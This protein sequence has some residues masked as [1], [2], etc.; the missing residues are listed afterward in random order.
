VDLGPS[1]RGGQNQVWLLLRGLRARGVEGELLGRAGAPLLGRAREEKFAVHAVA[2]SGARWRAAWKLRRLLRERHYDIV[3]AHDA[4]S[5]T[6]AWLAGAH[7]KARLVATR[8]VIY[9]PGGGPSG[10]RYRSAHRLVAISQAVRMAMVSSGIPEERIAVVYSGVELPAM[11]GEQERRNAREKFGFGTSDAVLGNVG[12][13]YRDKGQES[14]V[15]ALALLRETFPH[16]RL[17]LAGDGPERARLESLAQDLKLTG[18]V[19][20]PGFVEDVAQ[21]YAA[22]DVFLFPAVDEGLGTA[23]LAAMARVLPVVALDRGAGPEVIES[24]KS[25]LLLRDREPQTLAEAVRGLLTDRAAARRLGEAARARVAE[26]FSAERMVEGNLRVYREL[27]DE[28][29]SR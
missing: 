2:G 10:A 28:A 6:A 11:P 19:R 17:L 29:R 3:H 7:R 23:L 21:V 24:G 1:W 15:R 20:F 16:C 9:P 26:R 4:H 12:M 5:L 25:G 27:M 18:Q 13:F 14:L 22:L 8:R